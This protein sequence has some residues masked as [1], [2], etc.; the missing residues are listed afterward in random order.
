MALKRICLTA[1][2]AARGIINALPA[3]KM[4]AVFAATAATMNTAA[5]RKK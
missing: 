4:T 5:P 1:A 3:N 2:G